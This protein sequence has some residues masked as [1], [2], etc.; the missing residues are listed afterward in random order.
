MMKSIHSFAH[1]CNESLIHWLMY[2]MN[3]CAL[4]SHM[5][6]YSVLHGGYTWVVIKWLTIGLLIS[7]K[8]YI[9]MCLRQLWDERSQRQLRFCWCPLW[10]LQASLVSES[11]FILFVI[12]H[13]P[14]EH[15][16]GLWVAPRISGCSQSVYAPKSWPI[17]GSVHLDEVAAMGYIACKHRV[18][19]EKPGKE[20]PWEYTQFCARKG[21]HQLHAYNPPT[22][23]PI[24]TP[25]LESTDPKWWSSAHLSDLT[26]YSTLQHPQLQCPGLL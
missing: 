19:G 14:A 22:E 12:I 26:P 21:S 6:P 15:K 4:L 9:F 7:G 11:A 1:V 25:H 24:Q 16:W 8:K 3:S 17:F 13:Q 2:V 20:G 23:T 18:R 5:C 10:T